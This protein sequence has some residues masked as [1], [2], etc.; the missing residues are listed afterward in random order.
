[1]YFKKL[2]LYFSILIFLYPMIHGLLIYSIVLGLKVIFNIENPYLNLSLLGFK[3]TL[4]F[5]LMFFILTH[6]NNKKIIIIAL[7]IFVALFSTISFAK[8]I[9]LPFLVLYICSKY[10]NEIFEL[11]KYHKD[12]Y[13]N[14]LTLII[15]ITILVSLTDYYYRTNFVLNTYDYFEN[16]YLLII[17]KIS[18][19]KIFINSSS[20]NYRECLY[21]FWPNYYK[22][23]LDGKYY[24]SKHVIFMP[25]GNSVVLSYLLLYFILFLILLKEIKAK[26]D[27]NKIF[28]N[29][30]LV[31]L[32]CIQIYTF[33]RVN[34]LFTTLILVYYFYK[35][36][37]L[38]FIIPLICLFLINFNIIILSVFNQN[39]PS[40]LGHLEGYRKIFPTNLGDGEITMEFI[41][42]L[43]LV[44]ILILNIISKWKI[45]KTNFFIILGV[46]CIFCYYY[47]SIPISLFGSNELEIVESNFFKV[48]SNYGLVGTFL[49]IYILSELS[50]KLKAKNIYLKFLSINL[51]AY[52]FFSPY[53]IS[54]FVV[55]LP[56]VMLI[57]LYKKVNFGEKIE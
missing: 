29:L 21:N 5:I 3:E 2:I 38:H 57:T 1:M 45:S 17:N 11:F 14:L 50:D 39:T 51:L 12:R 19:S 36:Y 54:G 44:F 4:L 56:A 31:L 33:N 40:N 41:L 9:L 13:Y 27:S 7:F 32:G 30:T 18:C 55:F 46:F 47:F 48:L 43:I 28:F 37:L 15:F 20:E 52:Q 25:P 42:I 24:I 6:K 53:I 10:H 35:N 34:I 26:K 23:F 22:I 16:E 8:E 49:Y